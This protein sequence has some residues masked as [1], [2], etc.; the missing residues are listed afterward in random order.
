M[1]RPTLLHRL[2][3]PL[4]L[5]AALSTLPVLA[6]TA[7][8]PPDYSAAERLLLMGNQLQQVRP[9][10]TLTYRFQRSGTLEPPFEDQVG[11]QLTRQADGQCC[12]A[13]GAF[14]TGERRVTLPDLEQAQGNPVTLY[15]LEHDIREMQRLTMGQA[16]YFR[17]RIRMALYQGAQVRDVRFS[18]RGQTLAGQE[19]VIQPYLDDPNRARF[20]Q[21]AR[22]Q[23]VFLLSTAVPGT[24]VSIR[25]T[26]GPEGGSS[27]LIEEALWID[28]ATRPAYTPAASAAL[29]RTPPVRP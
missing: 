28:G 11:I 12:A 21:L 27:P 14:L 2:L 26:A 8:P 4:G 16:H 3:A 20:E 7:P 15:F 10:T 22:K 1:N 23:Y 25:T 29:T 24:V 17:K 13:T 19:I 18:Y 6:Q 5:V 9:P